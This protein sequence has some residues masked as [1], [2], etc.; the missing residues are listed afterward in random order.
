M[1]AMLAA[2]GAGF[3]NGIATDGI[4]IGILQHPMLQIFVS[5]SGNP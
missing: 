1:G 2:T 5:K 3:G 4:R